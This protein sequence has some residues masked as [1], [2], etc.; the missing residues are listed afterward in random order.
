VVQLLAFTIVAGALLP[1]AVT[2][3][4]AAT[5]TTPACLAKKLKEWGKLRQCQAT[6]NG[7]ALQGKE[8]D[9]AKCQVKFD[10]NLAKLNTKATKATIACRYGDNGDGTVTDYDTGLQWEQK[11]DDGS[12]H[13]KDAIYSWCAGGGLTDPCGNPSKPPDGPA[14]TVFLGTLNNGTSGDGTATSG[15]FAGHCD[16]RLPAIEEL[17]GILD[18]TAPGCLTFTGPCIDQ[19]VFGPIGVNGL[20]YWSATTL[21]SQPVGAW[22]VDFNPTPYVNVL[23]WNFKNTSN[24][25]VR[26]VRS[27]L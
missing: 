15:C 19:T 18:V 26:G 20:A 17:A 12:V 7:N 22:Y 24:V 13:D 23:D 2:P 9:P 27:G 6:E 16:W 3:A 1:E 4:D 11:T 14:F 5:L 25:N 8:A 21:A 10:D